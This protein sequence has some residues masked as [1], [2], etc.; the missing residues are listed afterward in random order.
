MSRRTVV[1]ALVGLGVVVAGAFAV[2][3]LLRDTT[4][5]VLDADRARDV[6][7]STTTVA[8]ASS[9]M[10]AGNGDVTV[11]AY[12]M[13]G[14]EEIDALAGARHDYPDETYL[15][16]RDGGCGELWRWQAIEERWSSWEVCDPQQVTVAGFDSFTHW[17]GVDDLEQYRCDPV[18][19]YL[20]PSPDTTT[21]TF[22]CGTDD[23]SQET[24]A[25]V[26][27]VETLDVGG[28]AVDTLHV[29]YTDT[30]S[31]SSSGGGET[32]RWFRLSDPLVIKEI[33]ATS[34][35]STSLI[36]T[37]HYTEEYEIA[38]TSLQPLEQ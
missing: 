24:T 22:T 31:G 18:A 29:H 38:L 28:V 21:W 13:A 3:S 2:V 7:V 37:V 15:T 9:T 6:A 30:L 33:G 19:S 23:I 26:V 17:F 12:A 4:T 8:G 27:G 16:I 11:Y 5:T 14:H 25:E 10:A 1:L 32:D 35:A 36:G 20:P 34:S